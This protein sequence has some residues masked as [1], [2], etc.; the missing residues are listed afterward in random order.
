MPPEPIG[1]FGVHYRGGGY[2]EENAFGFIL[3]VFKF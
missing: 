2:Y 3:R 1:W